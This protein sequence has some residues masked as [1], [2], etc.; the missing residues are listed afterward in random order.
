SD[1]R[2]AAAELDVRLVLVAHAALEPAALARE[3]GRVERQALRL[4]HL[5]RDGL[6]LPQ[7]RGAA[8]L[9]AAHAEP[10]RHLRL[11]ASADLLHLY[12][13]V[14]A[15]GDPAGDV[16]QVQ[17]I[18]GGDERRH[19]AAVERAL[20]LDQ[21]PR[22]V[23]AEDLEHGALQLALALEIAVLAREVPSVGL[24]HHAVQRAIHRTAV[25]RHHD[26]AEARSPLGLDQDPV[27]PPEL[28]H[29]GVEVVDLTGR[30]EPDADD[31]GKT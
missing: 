8:E 20:D 19:L 16:P 15:V 31:P 30:P 22:R 27:V 7:P 24:L 9:A 3:L 17:P 10:A 25:G 21:L 6:E 4:H 14:Q 29:A 28:Q 11:V 18:L 12:P 13:G 2:Q 5:H 1:R 26:R 23:A